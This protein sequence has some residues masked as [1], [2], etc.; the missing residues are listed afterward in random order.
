VR[1]YL[2][3]HRQFMHGVCRAGAIVVL[4]LASASTTSF[5]QV[6]Q[7]REPPL[8]ALRGLTVIDG[9]DLPPRPRTTVVISGARI[10][11]IQPDSAPLP[12]GAV[13]RNLT[14]RF[15]IPGLVDAHV[16]LGTQPRPVAVMEQI[17]RLAF[18]GGV[19]SVRDM[20]GQ[21][22]LVSR[23]AA[24]GNTDSMP[25]PRVTYGNTA[26]RRRAKRQRRTATAVSSVEFPGACCRARGEKRERWARVLL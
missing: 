12:A 4:L 6:S 26:R 23:F 20:S 8:V 9:T 15:V 14:G 22:E 16:H 3:H 7:S 19:T 13:E 25:M 18:L 5:L 24:L 2:H 10:A 1:S 21:F 11:R 17:L